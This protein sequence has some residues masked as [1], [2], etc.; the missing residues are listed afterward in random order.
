M[1]T[2]VRR[3]LQLIARERAFGIA[4]LAHVS[5]MTGLLLAWGPDPLRSMQ[6]VVLGLLLPWTAAR[7][8]ATR[9]LPVPGVR[10][11][12]A[13][14]ALALVVS[15]AF[16]VMLLADRMAGAG[17]A[18]ALRGE[19]PAQILSAGVAVLVLLWRRL[20]SDRVIGWIGATVTALLL[21]ALRIA[22]GLQ[23]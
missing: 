21:V 6:L 12:A 19:L 23:R 5:I 4:L 18:H 17:L 7:V 8:L 1:N 20:H 2:L 16:P 13:M 15:A 14:L 22:G 10:A 9:P 3:E 11:L